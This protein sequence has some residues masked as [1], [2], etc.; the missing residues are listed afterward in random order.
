MK[1]TPCKPTADL[2]EYELIVNLDDN[3]NESPVAV[4]NRR[5]PVSRRD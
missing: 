3:L 2:Y 5:S 4:H 1:L